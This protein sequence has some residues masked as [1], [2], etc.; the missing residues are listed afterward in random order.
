[1]LSPPSHS[2]THKPTYLTFI[3]LPVRAIYPQVMLLPPSHT[4]TPKPNSYL[5]VK[6]QPSSQHI[7]TPSHT[8]TPEPCSHILSIPIQYI[9]HLYRFLSEPYTPKSGFY[10]RAT[11]SPPSH[12]RAIISPLRH[13]LIFEPCFY[14]QVMLLPS[15]HALSLEPC[16]HPK[17]KL[18]LSGQ[19]TNPQS[20]N[21]HPRAMLSPL[22]HTFISKPIYSTFTPLPI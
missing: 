22:S 17:A 7:L 16:S 3:P 6:L 5:R 21:S 14:P 9:L 2:L 4:I 10:P 20:T 15:S 11:F 8:L 19:V 1:M 12:S 18:L 13:A